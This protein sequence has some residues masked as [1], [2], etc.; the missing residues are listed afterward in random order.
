M[1]KSATPR[2][3]A[4][5]T[6]GA[7]AAEPTVPT[8]EQRKAMADEAAALE[9]SLLAGDDTQVSVSD[10]A[11]PAVAELAPDLQSLIAREVAKGIAAFAASQRR[12]TASPDP[13]RELPSQHEVDPF[14]IK[15]EVLTKEGYVVPHQYPQGNIPN[16][17]R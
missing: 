12:A 10:S 9:E 14:T 4:V 8:E 1:T 16:A 2:V 7:P 15:K 3:Q 5:R 11:P 13:V 17:L 6:P